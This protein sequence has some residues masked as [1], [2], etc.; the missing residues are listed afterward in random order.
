VKKDLDV[1]GWCWFPTKQGQFE[2]RHCPTAGTSGPPSWWYFSNPISSGDAKKTAVIFDGDV[3]KVH[4]SSRSALSFEILSPF[5]NDGFNLLFLLYRH[6][7]VIVNT[8]LHTY[9]QVNDIESLPC[10]S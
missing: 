3:D 4:G 5:I 1:T 6:V 8:F 9:F 7:L 2:T 10:L